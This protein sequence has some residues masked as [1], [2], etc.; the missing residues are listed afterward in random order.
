MSISSPTPST[1]KLGQT[2]FSTALWPGPVTYCVESTRRT[3]WFP[4]GSLSIGACTRSSSQCLIEGGLARAVAPAEVPEDKLRGSWQKRPLHAMIHWLLLCGWI[5]VSC[6]ALFLVADSR[7]YVWW[8]GLYAI[9]H[10]LERH[11]AN[12]SE[13]R[14]FLCIMMPTSHV[15]VCEF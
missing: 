12:A 7:S 2:W 6:V 15:H 11:D 1:W 13:V 4:C 10:T 14:G 5:V 8:F 9:Q 3:D